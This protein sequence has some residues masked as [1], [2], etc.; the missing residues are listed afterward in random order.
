MPYLLDSCEGE[1]GVLCLR[2]PRENTAPAGVAESA[3]R[4]K[5]N[6]SATYECFVQRIRTLKAGK[7]KC[8]YLSVVEE[9]LEKEGG[10]DGGVVG[11]YSPPCSSIICVWSISARA[12]EVCRVSSVCA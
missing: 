9:G 1:E 4:K 7:Q 8:D 2:T 6:T 11:N 3:Q 10:G 12:W 5:C